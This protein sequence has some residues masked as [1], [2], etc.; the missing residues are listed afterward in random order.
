MANNVERSRK[1]AFAREMC[2]QLEEAL[3]TGAMLVSVSTDGISTTFNRAQALEEL[4]HWRKQVIRY[5]R[6]KSRVRN[7]DLSGGHD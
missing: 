7:I 1:L 3:R 2:S 5:S 4:E 6:C